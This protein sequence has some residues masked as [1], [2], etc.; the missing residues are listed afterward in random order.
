MDKKNDIETVK[1]DVDATGVGT[2]TNTT[3]SEDDKVHAI[4]GDAK[5][6]QP[7]VRTGRPDVPIAQTLASGT[8]AHTPPDPD[9]YDAD[10]RV[11]SVDV[12]AVLKGA[13]GSTK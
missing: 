3:P 2:I 10:G 13:V 1:I 6:D 5:Q 8:G 4:I 9:V 11:R 7:P 12:D